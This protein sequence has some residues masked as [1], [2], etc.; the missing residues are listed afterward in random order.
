MVA[1]LCSVF[2]T[3]L[4][5]CQQK[6]CFITKGNNYFRCTEH[7]M[8]FAM[9]QANR[10]HCSEMLVNTNVLEGRRHHPKQ[11]WAGRLPLEGLRFKTVTSY[12][13]ALEC[14]ATPFLEAMR[15]AHCHHSVVALLLVPLLLMC[16]TPHIL[17]RMLKKWIG[18]I[19][20]HVNVHKRN[21]QS[22]VSWA[23]HLGPGVQEARLPMKTAIE[24][25]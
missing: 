14:H 2:L 1:N 11:N 22:V 23:P 9:P 6:E 3:F 15:I 17:T 16:C 21:N 8:M 18:Y 5:I 25:P 12:A 7:R 24:Q 4:T 20:C 19:P 10:Q 13:S